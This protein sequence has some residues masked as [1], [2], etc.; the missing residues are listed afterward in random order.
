M[1]YYL[2]KTFK[3]KFR[4]S[5]AQ[6]GEDLMLNVLFSHIKNGIYIDVGANDPYFQSNTQFFYMK[7][8][9]GINIDANADSIKLFNRKRKKDINVEALVSNNNDEMEYYYYEKS[10][11]N[12]CVYRD[13]IPSR[14]LYS[15]KLKSISLTTILQDKGIRDIH[16]L[17]IDVEGLDLDVL[18]SLDLVQI[19]PQ[20]IIIESF[21]KD[22]IS[23]INS[24]ISKYL[25]RYKYI[26]YSRSVTNT[27]YLSKEFHALRFGSNDISE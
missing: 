11:Y 7:G 5:Y 8:W 3:P 14:L 20:A 1:F 17:S 13:D 6:S 19:R 16:F 25:T 12:G 21:E 2:K 9:R 4:K 26:Y 22:L 10:A 18:Q 15:K 24:E 27:I 23:D